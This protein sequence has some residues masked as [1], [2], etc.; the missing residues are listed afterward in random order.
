MKKGIGSLKALHTLLSE[1]T[2][3]TRMAIIKLIP[4]MPPSVAKLRDLDS[5]LIKS[6]VKMF[7][8]IEMFPAQKPATTLPR[9]STT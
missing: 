5:L 1:K 9:T 2:P 8:H 4:A 3:P 7:W 6:E